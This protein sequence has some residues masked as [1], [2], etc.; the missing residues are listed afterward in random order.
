MPQTV[1][2][3]QHAPAAKVPIVVAPNRMDKQEAD[4]GK[5]K[6]G[7]EQVASFQQSGAARISSCRFA[8]K[9]V[10][11]VDSAAGQPFVQAK[12]WK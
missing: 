10:Q 4:A 5:V 9:P 12:C 2:A 11:G 8:R 3:I 1:E 6:K 7:I